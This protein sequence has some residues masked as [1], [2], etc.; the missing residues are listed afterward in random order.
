MEQIIKDF[1][2]G[3]EKKLEELQHLIIQQID[4]INNQMLEIENLKKRLDHNYPD[5]TTKHVC[6]NVQCQTDQLILASTMTQTSLSSNENSSIHHGDDFTNN[7]S[8]DHDSNIEN[9]PTQTEDTLYIQEPQQ[10][11]IQHKTGKMKNQLPG[12][13][14]LCKFFIQGHCKRGIKC[15]F[16][17]EE[18][19]I[20][21]YVEWN[22][23]MVK[24]FLL[25]RVTNLCDY[26]M[27]GNYNFCI[28]AILYLSGQTVIDYPHKFRKY[29]AICLKKHGLQ[30]SVNL[31]Y[32][33]TH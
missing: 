25:A 28:Q 20:G 22:D 9:P 30:C 19:N 6:S 33:C 12:N 1:E 15:N 8:I 14:T 24:E 2:S 13:T 29:M 32:G 31:K 5:P 11:Q 23:K 21:D 17:H 26:D 18:I 3:L 27:Y 16:V 4:V 10:L 7:L